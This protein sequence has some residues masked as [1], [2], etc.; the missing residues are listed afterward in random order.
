LAELLESLS[1]PGDSIG[2]KLKAVE[3][4]DFDSIDEA[5]EGHKIRNAIAHEGSDFLITEREAKRVISL[6]KKV[7]S[8]F[9]II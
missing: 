6:F 1:L 9:E 8:E 2:E 3:K 4:S 7:F 5:W